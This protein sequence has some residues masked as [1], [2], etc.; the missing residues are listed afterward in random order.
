MTE[1][2]SNGNGGAGAGNGG[3]N[4]TN[5]KFPD[6]WN[7][8]ASTVEARFDRV[9][10]GRL[11]A[12]VV[13]LLQERFAFRRS[14]DNESPVTFERPAINSGTPTKINVQPR[15]STFP[16]KGDKLFTPTEAVYVLAVHGRLL[17]AG[18]LD[19]SNGRAPGDPL[20]SGE[21]MLQMGNTELKAGKTSDPKDQLTQDVR[22]VPAFI[23]AFVDAVQ[24][25]HRNSELY[26]KVYTELVDIGITPDDTDS[27]DVSYTSVFAAQLAEVVDRLVD[28]GV[29]QHSPQLGVHI[30]QAV[31]QSV[32]G[33]VTGRASAIKVDLPS[34]DDGGS[35]AEILAD[36]VSAL[37]VLYFAA[38]L[39][40]MQFFSTAETLAQ[41]FESGRLPLTRGSG[42]DNIYEYIRTTHKRFN[43]VERRSMYARAFGF[44]QGGLEVEMPNRSFTDLWLRGL[45]AV[46]AFAR[47]YHHGNLSPVSGSRNMVIVNSNNQSVHHMQVYKALRDLGL[48][49]SLHGYGMAHFAAV[50]LQETIRQTKRM[51]SHPQ[52]MGAF[53]A[54]SYVQLIERVT[55]MTT[56]SQ[57]N[58]V[59]QRVLAEAGSQVMLW[60]GENAPVLAS[61]TPPTADKFRE[62]MLLSNVEKWLAVTGTTDAQVEQ[63]SEPQ[64]VRSQPTIPALSLG[65]AGAALK[66]A[67]GSVG[68]NAGLVPEA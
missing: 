49:L 60:I 58:P 17:N 5:I 11:Y 7:D 38:Q 31:G 46:S 19:P 15:P 54:H 26:Q 48:N 47:Q 67:L 35:S 45:S 68:V 63:F 61:P 59:R 1:H 24:A 23:S 44:A 9:L 65:G 10:H 27:D 34:L 14:V 25:Y 39:E 32:S 66:D 2:E 43:E 3:G 55:A 53:G 12:V 51:L 18:M 33:S 41:M 64:V 8:G 57:I 4:D 13:Y 50:E 21:E 62:E 56:G 36:N 52:V 42:G 16:D 28:H 37:A 30:R 20:R 22:V 29:T 40:D 6:V